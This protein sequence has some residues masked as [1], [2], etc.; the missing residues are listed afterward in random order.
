VCSQIGIMFD[1]IYRLTSLRFMN[2]HSSTIEVLFMIFVL[3]VFQTSRILIFFL[4][5][6]PPV[7]I[8]QIRV[9]KSESESWHTLVPS[10]PAGEFKAVR[11]FTFNKKNGFEEVHILMKLFCVRFFLSFI[12]FFATSFSPFLFRRPRHFTIPPPFRSSWPDAC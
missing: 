11:E 3:V 12:S 10:A 1:G 4:W 6:L 7:Y 9:R 8:N 5:Y 2:R